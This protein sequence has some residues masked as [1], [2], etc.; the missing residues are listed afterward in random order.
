MDSHRCL[1]LMLI[2]LF[3]VLAAAILTNLLVD[4]WG[5]WRF[6]L[7][8]GRYRRVV[9]ERVAVPYLLRGSDP[10]TILLGSSRVRLGMRIDQELKDGVLNAAL[11]GSRLPEIAKEVN[12]AVRNP[13][14]KRIVWGIEFYLLNANDNLCSPQTC[15]RL[16]GDLRLKLTD[17]ILS[18]DAL[19]ASY[20]MALRAVTGDL[21]PQARM[22]IPWPQSYICYKF[23]HPDPPNLA[24]LDDLHRLRELNDFPYYRDFAYSAR[25]QKAFLDV[26]ERIRDAHV[27]LIAFVPPLTRFELE[28]LRQTGGW[29]AFQEWKRFL[30][31]HLNYTDFSGYN[32]ISRTDRLF[33]DAWHMEP[34]AGAA[35]MRKLMGYS[36]PQC[37]DAAIVFHSAL[38]VTADNIDQMLSIQ[39][40]RKAAAVA[41]SSPYSTLVKAAIVRRYGRSSVNAFSTVR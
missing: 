18:S 40:Q 23:E 16:D 21:S 28:M 17:T 5:A 35:I 4:P 27:E 32:E 39:E 6:G 8:A 19:A 33:I 15:A 36:V 1:R 10:D 29:P 37:P 7:V 34:A 31:Q 20:R 41:A 2:G 24:K 14:L 13:H 3:A 22:P 30:A 9:D 38:T 26:V 11:A 25:Q 12:L